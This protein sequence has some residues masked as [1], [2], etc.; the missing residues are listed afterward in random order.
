MALVV[1]KG[2]PAPELPPHKAGGA[3]A[4]EPATAGGWTEDAASLALRL[5]LRRWAGGKLASYKI[6]SALRLLTGTSDGG[7][8]RNAMGKV[9]K[10]ALRAE[11]FGPPARA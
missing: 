5:E 8:P 3:P 7:L 4:P 2:P 6:P 10:K 1:P 9:N 11:F